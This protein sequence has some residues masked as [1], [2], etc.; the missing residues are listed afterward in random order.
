MGKGE[1]VAK[2]MIMCYECCPDLDDE[3]VVTGV[4]DAK[5]GYQGEGQDGAILVCEEWDNDKHR[6]LNNKYFCD[7]CGIP[8]AVPPSSG[9]F[10]NNHREERESS[11][12]ENQ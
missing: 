9:W 7:E 1:G 10:M 3:N 12:K 11:A 6:V 5:E 8:I 4:F 2:W